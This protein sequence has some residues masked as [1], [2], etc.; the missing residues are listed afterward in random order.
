MYGKLFA[1]L[2][3]GTLRGHAH[4]ILVFSNMIAHADK[5]G[6]VDK[7]WRAIAEEC[8]LS[9]DEVKA[10]CQKLEAPDPESRSAEADGAR[11]IRVDD[12]RAWGWRITNYAKYRA[13]RSEEDRRIQ[14]R[15]AKRRER[16]KLANLSQCQPPSATVSHGQPRSAHAEAEAEEEAVTTPHI[17]EKSHVTP[18]RVCAPEAP[19][20]TK[21]KRFEKPSLEEVT[22][23][24]AKVGLPEAEAAKFINHYESNGW[25]VG[26]NPM[27][28]WPHAVGN[29]AQ[30][31]RQ[32]QP[33]K[34]PSL[35]GMTPAE[36]DAE[37][38][39]WVEER[40]AE[41]EAF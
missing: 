41:K 7:H 36:M 6:F 25:R 22:L 23:A 21:S 27:K 14:N 1:S 39:R 31:F 5:D 24:M 37:T 3:H 15:D 10:A 12:H 8:G 2:Y 35:A 32:F 38:A 40:N 26:R 19:I 13:I 28:S 20:D 30:N 17:T 16:E 9:V 29:W 34:Q 4:E 11:I 18:S 33:R